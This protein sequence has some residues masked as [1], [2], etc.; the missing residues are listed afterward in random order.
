MRLWSAKRESDSPLSP[1]RLA[2]PGRTLKEK[3]MKLDKILNMISFSL[4]FLAWAII[5]FFKLRY[6]VFNNNFIILVTL[7]LVLIITYTIFSF[8]KEKIISLKLNEKEQLMKIRLDMNRIFAFFFFSVGISFLI[9]S[10]P[11]LLERVRFFTISIL[12]FLLA[13]IYWYLGVMPRYYKL[14]K[15]YGG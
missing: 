7:F 9:Y 14:E 2:K 12:S 6:N 5:I 13:L 4:F 3:K 11:D 10:M 15:I 1:F 8:F